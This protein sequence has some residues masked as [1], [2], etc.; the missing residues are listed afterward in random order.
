MPGEVTLNVLISPDNVADFE[1]FYPEWERET[2]IK[3]K[4][5][6]VPWPDWFKELMDISIT[7]SDKYDV[8][9]VCPKWVPDL[10]EAKVFE[11]LNPYIEKYKPQ[12]TS[13]IRILYEI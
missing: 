4:T 9:M 11:N 2:G 13:R 6:T 7:K 8:L 1:P 10:A 12:I 3:L 5:Y